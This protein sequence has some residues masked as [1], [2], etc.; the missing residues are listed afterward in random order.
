MTTATA[1]DDRMRLVRRALWTGLA[2]QLALAVLPLL[3]LA[4]L[5][6]IT[7]HV[8][9]AYPD[10]SAGDVALDR[11]AIAWSL[12]GVGV[13]GAV[14]WLVALARARRGAPRATVTVLFALGLLTALTLLGTGG[15][16]YDVIVPLGYGLLGLLPVLAGLAALVAVWRKDR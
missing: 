14:G 7:G 6:T 12:A 11:N 16:A 2:L 5:D 3:D 15:E 13:L 9:A 1:T 8:E 4:T 10:W